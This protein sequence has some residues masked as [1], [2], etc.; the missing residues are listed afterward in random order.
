VYYAG[1]QFWAWRQGRVRL[2]RDYVDKAL[3]IFPLKKSST[4]NVGWMRRLW[5]IR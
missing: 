2:L 4:A 1:P 3:L 5:A